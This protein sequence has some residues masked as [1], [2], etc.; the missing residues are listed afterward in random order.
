MLTG[1]V[2]LITTDQ[3]YG[4]IIGDDGGERLFERAEQSSLELLSEGD[5][6]TFQHFHSTK[7]AA[8]ADVKLKP[9]PYCKKPMH[10][11]AHMSVCPS[12]P[13]NMAPP[14][15]AVKAMPARIGE[16][17][18]HFVPYGSQPDRGRFY[19]YDLTNAEVGMY[20]HYDNAVR[21]AT[22]LPILTEFEE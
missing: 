3:K 17:M 21:F 11:S 7:G 8:A 13:A 9:C 16:F 1:K 19:L 22:G 18:V 12:R 6:V 10:T 5:E 2:R 14:M 15:Q 4:S 20:K